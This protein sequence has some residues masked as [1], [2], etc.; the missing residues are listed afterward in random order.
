VKDLTSQRT[1]SDG[2]GKSPVFIVLPMRPFLTL[3]TPILFLLTASACRV[4]CS[5]IGALR[6]MAE[7][8]RTFLKVSTVA[9]SNWASISRDN[10]E[11]AQRRNP[12]LHGQ[13]ADQIHGLLTWRPTLVRSCPASEKGS[14]A[15]FAGPSEVAFLPPPTQSAF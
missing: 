2:L 1:R 13:S 8:W 14:S 3:L 9:S 6:G 11:P 4:S 15:T 7:R 12:N 10:G 5:D